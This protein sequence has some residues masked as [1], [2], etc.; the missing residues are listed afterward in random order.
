LRDRTR[1]AFNV[2]KWIHALF[3]ISKAITRPGSFLIKKTGGVC[4]MLLRTRRPA[5][6]LAAYGVA[7]LRHASAALRQASAHW[8]IMAPTF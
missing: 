8:R 4:Q 1:D 3:L 5:L 7:S 2:I 6:G